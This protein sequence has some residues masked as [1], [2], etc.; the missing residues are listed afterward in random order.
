M[1]TH[2]GSRS[3][4][5]RVHSLSC[6]DGFIFI[7]KFASHVHNLIWFTSIL[8]YITIPC[9]I[10]YTDMCNWGASLPIHFAVKTKSQ[11]LTTLFIHSNSG[12]N[13]IA[14]ISVEDDMCS[15]MCNYVENFASSHMQIPS[16][17]NQI[18]KTYT[19]FINSYGNHNRRAFP[20]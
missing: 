17:Q 13:L 15:D 9:I 5:H 4:A 7:H 11:K 2:L 3:V 16:G 6:F 8:E 10:F 12:R 20:S 1:E 19:L 18:T 14:H